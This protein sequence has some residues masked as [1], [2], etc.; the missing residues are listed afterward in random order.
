L[1]KQLVQ[2][3][4]NEI[5]RLRKFSGTSTEGVIS[6]AFKD[7]LKA[8]SRQKNLQF[9]AQYEFESPQK[10]RIRPDGT[11]LHDLRVPLGY[12]EAKDEA[13]DLDVEI[14]KK[15]KKGY[16]QDNIIFEDSREAVLIQNRAEVYVV[17]LGGDVRSNTKISGTKHN[18]FGIQTGVAISFLVKRRRS[19]VGGQ[20]RIAYV[21]RPEFDTADEKLSFLGNSKLETVGFDRI[22]PDKLNSWVGHSENEW[23]ELLPIAGKETKTTKWPSRERSIFKTYSLG[24]VTNRDEWVTD[25][26]PDIAL[27]KVGTLL[28]EYAEAIREKRTSDTLDGTGIKW[29][30]DLKRS[31]DR[32]VQIKVDPALVVRSAYRPFVAKQLYYSPRLNEM[33]YQIPMLFPASGDTN[34]AFAWVSE[35]RGA[36]SALGF[37]GIPNKDM[38]MPSAGQVVARYRYA[39]DGTRCDNIT[40]WGLKQFQKAYG[41]NGVLDPARGEGGPTAEDASTDFPSPLEGEG[42]RRADEG[43]A[44]PLADPSSVSALRADPPSPSRG[45]GKRRQLTK[46]D[47]FHYVYAVLHDPVYRERYALNLKRE[48]PRIPFYP[49]FWKWVGWGEKLMALHIGYEGVEPWPL[50][51]I[52]VVDE[53]ALAAGVAPKAMLKA[54]KDNGSIRLDSETQLTGVPDEAWTYRLGNRSGVEWV[55]DQYKE[56]TPKDPTIREKFNTYRFADYKEKVIELI[57]RVTRVSV[58]TVAITEAMKGARR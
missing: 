34:P 7:L 44:S 25:F 57:G 54:D 22:E 37:F 38:F 36:F 32:R 58:E 45:E 52:D 51:R 33:L 26:A 29:T 20:A 30:R 18:V 17:D 16:P 4:F 55:L 6:E 47:I 46:D 24:V 40:D 35:P 41:M 48:F 31:L 9:I 53:R 12:W 39:S 10:N 14:E 19:K 15:L 28:R 49:D 8:W 1:S 43:S 5:D 3:Y 23:D 13:D 56:K 42:A 27:L 21:R 50:K 2:D 11:I